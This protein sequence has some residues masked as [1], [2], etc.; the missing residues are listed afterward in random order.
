[1]QIDTITKILDI[2]K[3]KV[4]KIIQN[5]S[6]CLELVLEPVEDDA[7]P[8]GRRCIF[9]NHQKSLAVF[10]NVVIEAGP[11]TV[12]LVTGSEFTARRLSNSEPLYLDLRC[13][14]H[15]KPFCIST[16]AHGKYSL[17]L[18]VAAFLIASF[19]LFAHSFTNAV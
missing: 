13:F 10:R 11:S 1:M 15:E 7:D 17:F 9:L 19:E 18:S 16:I 8:R 2:P 12:P 6:D 5:T 3:H 14:Q 4:K